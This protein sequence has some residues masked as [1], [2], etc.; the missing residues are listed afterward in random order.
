MLRATKARIWFAETG[1]L[2][3]RDNGSR[4]EFAD[5]PKHAVKATRMVIRLAPPQPADPARL[6]LPLGR[7]GPAHDLGL[8]IIDRRGRPRPQYKVVRSYMRHCRPGKTCRRPTRVLRRRRCAHVIASVTFG[9]GFAFI[10]LGRAELFT[11][12]F[13]LPWAPYGRAARG[14]RPYAARRTTATETTAQTPGRMA[15]PAGGALELL[16]VAEPE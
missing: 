14:S 12:N 2:V 16:T 11:E 3:R 8:A 4:I 10:T 6:L 15:S 7:A 13:L 9:I 1:G 5:S